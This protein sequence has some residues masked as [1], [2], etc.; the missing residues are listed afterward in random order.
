ML[1]NEQEEEVEGKEVEA[2]VEEEEAGAEEVA[3]EMQ[4]EIVG[5]RYPRRTKM[6]DGPEVTE[7]DMAFAVHR[8]GVRALPNGT[9]TP[10]EFFMLFN[11]FY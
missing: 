7:P 10:L 8:T 4:V 1:E 6:Q 3:I 9:S 11:I 2:E 5:L